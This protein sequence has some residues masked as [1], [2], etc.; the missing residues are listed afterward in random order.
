MMSACIVGQTQKISST[1]IQPS[2]LDI[3]GV[4]HV[5]SNHSNWHW[6]RAVENGERFSENNAMY[7][8]K[9]EVIFMVQGDTFQTSECRLGDY[10]LWS[11]G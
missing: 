6:N 4:K 1:A 7:F 8:R 2:L 5:F 3:V 9:H 11:V 10:G